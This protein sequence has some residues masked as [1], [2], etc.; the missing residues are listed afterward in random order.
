VSEESKIAEEVKEVNPI[1]EYLNR[2]KEQRLAE[3]CVCKDKEIQNRKEERQKLIEQIADMRHKVERYEKAFSDVKELY[4]E[5][6]KLSVDDYLKL[7]HMISG[8]ISG[9]NRVSSA[10]ISPFGACFTTTR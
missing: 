1:D 9:Y 7:Y 6:K 5:I 2:Y 8:D 10:T 4:S 3:F